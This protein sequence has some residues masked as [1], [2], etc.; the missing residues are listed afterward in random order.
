SGQTYP[1]TPLSPKPRSNVKGLP[2]APIPPAQEKFSLPFYTHSQLT[3]R[4][5]PPQVAPGY[6]EHTGVPEGSEGSEYVEE[7]QYPE[8]TR[9]REYMAQESLSPPP[10]FDTLSSNVPPE[11]TPSVAT[12]AAEYGATDGPELSVPTDNPEYPLEMSLQPDS[13]PHQQQMS[14]Q[15]PHTEASFSSF[16][17]GETASTTPSYSINASKLPATP[18]FTETSEGYQSSG[19]YSPNPPIESVSV[20]KPRTESTPLQGSPWAPGPQ[21]ASPPAEAPLPE[22]YIDE[23]PYFSP[24]E[25]LPQTVDQETMPPLQPPKP[26]LPSVKETTP[27]QQPSEPPQPLITVETTG[28]S[29]SSIAPE[30]PKPTPPPE[31][32]ELP[33]HTMAPGIPG[34]PQQTTVS[35]VQIYTPQKEVTFPPSHSETRPQQSTQYPRPST[36]GSEKP[37]PP[38]GPAF[39]GKSFT[40]SEFKTPASSSSYSTSPPTRP[41]IGTLPQPSFPETQ[42]S[43][44]SVPSK[45]TTAQ[46]SRIASTRPTPPLPF[47]PSKIVPNRIRGKAHVVCEEI[48]LQFRITTLFPF[49]GQIFAH[50]RKRVPGCVHTFAEA[51]VINI[52]LPYQECGIRNIG[53]R[54]AETQYHMQIIVV[55]EQNDGKSTIQSFIAQCQHQKVQY[56]KST[57][58][59]RI[60]EALE[61]LRLVP[62]K[63]EQ[64]API[65]ECVMRIVKEADHGHEGDGV[66]VDMVDL[67]QPMRIEW[68][69]VPESGLLSIA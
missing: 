20:E 60:E 4:P 41:S 69:L 55:F 42:T 23:Y 11:Y 31:Q 10:K 64:K 21:G 28:F 58:P 7:P 38:R 12:T 18:P 54:R 34:V 25:E 66:E 50:D 44:Y 65:P 13:T 39:P 67:G 51:A 36:I 47:T 61:E 53:E 14:F 45:F 29:P 1:V 59:K 63:L 37:F 6:L 43:A 19:F 17:P 49:T 27:P 16:P 33:Q 22:G 48:G 8:P 30:F 46:P 52:T 26:H 62:T 57:I 24:T 32:P 9:S 2:P 35:T 56:Q 3:P 40:P 5:V 68:S 15:S